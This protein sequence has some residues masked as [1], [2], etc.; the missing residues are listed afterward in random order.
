MAESFEWDENK[1]RENIRRRGINFNDAIRI[2]GDVYYIE[3]ED[4]RRDYGEQRFN[5]IGMVSG[6]ILFVTYTYLWRK[7]SNYIRKE[8]GTP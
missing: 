6:R 2:F 8:G 5:V 7:N 1:N 3:G 4:D